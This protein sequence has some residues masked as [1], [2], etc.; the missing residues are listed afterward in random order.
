MTNTSETPLA[1]LFLTLLMQSRF[2]SHKLHH[3]I[4]LGLDVPHHY[5]LHHVA[6]Q[7]GND[8]SRQFPGCR[9]CLPTLFSTYG[10][11]DFLKISPT[12]PL[13]CCEALPSH[14]QAITKASTWATK[15][16]RVCASAP[17]PVTPP[18]FSS[19]SSANSFHPHCLS[20][21]FLNMLGMFLRHR[22]GLAVPSD[23]DALSTDIY[24]GG[25]HFLQNSCNTT[26]IRVLSWAV[27]VS[28]HLLSRTSPL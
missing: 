28:Q 1:L 23:W 8:R 14:Y 5:H 26:L 9:L 22:L 20:C 19:I 11:R 21:H 6:S 15:P 24:K 2:T 17:T 18:S 12:M 13:P 3:H 10:Q 27:H 7:D 25:P 16:Q 4:Y